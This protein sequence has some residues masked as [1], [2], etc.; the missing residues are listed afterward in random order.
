MHNNNSVS[1]NNNNPQT[2]NTGKA[3][4]EHNTT[5]GSATSGDAMNE[6]M[7]DASVTFHNSSSGLANMYGGNMGSDTASISNTGPNSHN[8]VEF[9]NEA[10]LTVTNSNNVQISNTNTQSATSGSAEVE[11]NTTGGDAT[12]GGASNTSSNTFSIDITN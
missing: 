9:K 10:N 2:A 12:S 5:G 1:L 4:V 6:S 11:G 3:E 7:L 8:E